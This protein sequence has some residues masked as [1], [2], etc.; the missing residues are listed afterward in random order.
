MQRAGRHSLK[1][2]SGSED[3]R[4][5]AA[6]PG[7]ESETRRR[8][9]DG[10]TETQKRNRQCHTWRWIL[11]IGEELLRQAMKG[12]FWQHLLVFH[13]YNG[14][15]TVTESDQCYAVPGPPLSEARET[16]SRVSFRL[17]CKH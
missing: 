8:R 13:G 16:T 3:L 7:H 12:A 11:A 10:K 17:C 2:G 15:R 1:T 4:Q 9:E 5:R 6:K 14:F